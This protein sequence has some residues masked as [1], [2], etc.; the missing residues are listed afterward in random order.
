MNYKKETGRSRKEFE[1]LNQ[2]FEKSNPIDL[3]KQRIEKETGLSFTTDQAKEYLEEKFDIDLSDE[4][5][6]VKARIELNSYIKPIKEELFAQ[7]E[8]FR[9]PIEKT[10]QSQSQEELVKLTD[11]SMMKK[12]DYQ[13]L[14][15]N[16]QKHIQN[17]IASVDSVTGASFETVFDDNGTEKKLS[18]NY[19]YSNEDKQ[20]M[21]SVVKDVDAIMEQR[22]RS[23]EGDFNHK[24]FAEDL[25]W[26]DP[27]NRGKAIN[28]LINKARAEAIEEFMKIEGNINFSQKGI[29]ASK[30]KGTTTQQTTTNGYGFNS[31]FLNP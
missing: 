30:E 31:H 4:E 1:F 10:P 9:Q 24:Q 8:K 17:A 6:S 11:G 13:K 25:F 28:T 3:A 15:D 21:L 26:S 14:Q 19:D 7:K 2:D 20:S 12:E 23:K 18:Y 16:H 5:L 27:K 29:P 22:Y